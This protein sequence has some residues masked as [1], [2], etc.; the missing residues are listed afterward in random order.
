MTF[1]A[2]LAICLGLVLLIWSADRF[3]DGAAVSA[4]YFGVSPLIIGMVV[5]GFGTSAPE[6]IVSGFAAAGGNPGVA[7]GNAYGSNIANIGLILGLAALISPILVSSQVIRKELPILMGVTLLAAAQAWS[8]EINRLSGIVLLSVFAMLMG[9]TIYVGIQKKADPL[10]EEVERELKSHKL[11]LNQA[12]FWLIVG[13]IVLI[14]SARLLVWGAVALAEMLGVSEIIIGLTIIAVGTSLPELAAT[15]SALRKQES[16]IVIGNVIG[17]NLFNTLAVVG[18][19]ALIKPFSVDR[20]IFYRDITLM[21]LM[22]L[23]TFVFGFRFSRKRPGR[24]NRIEGGILLV[25]YII[26]L[27]YLVMVTLQRTPVTAT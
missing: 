22:T 21:F 20:E 25:S 12:I 1:F 4:D 16:D 17:S 5:V 2:V 3:V 24:I 9:W 14:G 15:F 19:A 11:T 6:L 23:A 26:Y 8:G 7:L 27:A 18:I 13:L 10:A